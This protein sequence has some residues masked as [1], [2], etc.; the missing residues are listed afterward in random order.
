MPPAHRAPAHVRR[1]AAEIVKRRGP[2][3]GRRLRLHLQHQV[4]HG[5]SGALPAPRGAPPVANAVQPGDAATLGA[6]RP[7][8]KADGGVLR[9]GRG[10]G[11]APGDARLGAVARRLAS[12]HGGHR[13]ARAAAGAQLRAPLPR[14]APPTTRACARRAA[15]G[16]ARAPRAALRRRGQDERGGEQPLAARG[17]AAG[18]RL[19]LGRVRRRCGR[20]ARVAA[21]RR[22]LAGCAHQRDAPTAQGRAR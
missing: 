9:R 16:A 6:L 2:M 3:A 22:P 1:T 18:A 5:G 11:R 8:R 20:G 17:A 10:A 13:G 12:E 21:R 14:D 4:R 19:A 15:G 7:W